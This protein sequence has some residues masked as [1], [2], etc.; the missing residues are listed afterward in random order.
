MLPKIAEE[1]KGGLGEMRLIL[2]HQQKHYI[3]KTIETILSNLT[4]NIF[5]NHEIV[6][7]IVSNI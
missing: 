2:F 1:G 3:L 7:G 6:R 4:I 5:T